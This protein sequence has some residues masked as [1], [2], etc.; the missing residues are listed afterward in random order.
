MRELEPSI[1]GEIEVPTSSEEDASVRGEVCRLPFQAD[2]LPQAHQPAAGFPRGDTNSERNKN[3]IET[4][5]R[6]SEQSRT[7]ERRLADSCWFI[8][9]SNTTPVRP[10]LAA[11]CASVRLPL[12]PFIEIDSRAIRGQLVTGT[13]RF[14]LTVIRELRDRLHDGIRLSAI[15]PDGGNRHQRRERRPP[16]SGSFSRGAGQMF[17]SETAEALE[18]EGVHRERRIRYVLK[19]LL[20]FLSR[21]RM[22]ILWR[23]GGRLGGRC[24]AM[25]G[26]HSV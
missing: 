2:E 7:V 12:V 11:T 13:R 4:P 10:P 14:R 24:K 18:S 20:R 6:P 26:L 1:L 23:P 8:T 22:T 17:T 15:P 3:H 9:P 5:R 19:A 25:A 21:H 16:Q